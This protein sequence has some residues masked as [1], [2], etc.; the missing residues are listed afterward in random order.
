MGCN[1]SFEGTLLVP[2]NTTT[3]ELVDTLDGAIR[4]A[5]DFGICQVEKKPGRKLE[6]YF[7]VGGSMGNGTQGDINAA[8]EAFEGMVLEAAWVECVVDRESCDFWVG[9]PHLVALAEAEVAVRD[10]EAALKHHLPNV[11]P[12]HRKKLLAR[13]RALT[14]EVPVS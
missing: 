5:S 10:F 14:K 13:I 2:D 1:A 7:S 11:Q 9:P 4:G 3:R 8:V 6:V 12:K